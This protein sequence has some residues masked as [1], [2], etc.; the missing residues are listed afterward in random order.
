[1]KIL[2]CG[3]LFGR[4]ALCY[5]FRE[6]LKQLNKYHTISIDGPS[7]GGYWEKFY[8]NFKKGEEDIYLLNGHTPS[9]KELAKKHKKI[10]NICVLECKLPGS[11][12]EA[13]NLPEVKEIWTISKFCK[14]LI[15]NSGVNKPV[16]VIYLGVDERLKKK[17]VNIFPADKSF[18]FL[19][20]CAPHCLGVRSQR[21]SG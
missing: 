4:E 13:L 19:C 21:V 3:G 5:Q 12:V 10:I 17:G 20:I 8:N 18:K 14:E 1:M 9:I 6:I 2:C 11:W 15:I 7:T 16:K